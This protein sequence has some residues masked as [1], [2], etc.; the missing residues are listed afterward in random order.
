MCVYKIVMVESSQGHTAGGFSI[1]THTLT[2]THTQVAD[3]D[4]AV[5]E[6]LP[7]LTAAF[8]HPTRIDYGTGVCVCVCVCVCM[9]VGQA[10]TGFSYA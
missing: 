6:L 5:G 1:H 2:H 10:E 3:I 4:G 7:Y 8:G 9:Y